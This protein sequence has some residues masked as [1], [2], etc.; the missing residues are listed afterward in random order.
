MIGIIMGENIDSIVFNPYIAFLS[1]N[2]GETVEETVDDLNQNN[3]EDQINK[4]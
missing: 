4:N 2:E 1:T 3:N